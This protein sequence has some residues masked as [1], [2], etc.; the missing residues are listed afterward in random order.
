MTLTSTET[1]KAALDQA[2]PNKVADALQKIALGTV[3]TPIVY[4]TGVLS[5]A[6]IVAAIPLPSPALLVQ[7]ARVVSSGTAASVGTYLVSD[8]SAV[9]V[10]PPG[11][12][13]A[14]AGVAKLAADGTTVTFPNTVTR[15]IIQ[16]IRRPVSDE[17]AAFVRA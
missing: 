17:T 4:D 2:N 3:L 6:L 7:S 11:G 13:S 9:A 5:G 1:L 10:I 14:A 12:A 8:A 15:A 16:Y